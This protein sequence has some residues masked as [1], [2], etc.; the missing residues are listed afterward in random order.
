MAFIFNFFWCFCS[1]MDEVEQQKD[2]VV[3]DTLEA[4]KT[5]ENWLLQQRYL[6]FSLSSTMTNR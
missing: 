4:K 5:A 6:D 2:S 3:T 1:L